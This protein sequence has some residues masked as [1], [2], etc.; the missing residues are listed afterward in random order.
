M[1]FEKTF[2]NAMRAVDTKLLVRLVARDD[3]R[4]ASLADEFI[5]PGAWVSHLVLMEMTWVLDSVYDLAQAEI[6]DAV[7]ML[8]N[9]VSLTVQEADTVALALDQFRSVPALGFS[10]C[11]ILEVAKKAGHVPLGTF[12]RRLGRLDGTQ[13][14]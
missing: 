1:A 3:D 7:D 13:R 4:H 10:D 5:A 8:L 12:D 6:G 9:H 11:L 14:L 2:A